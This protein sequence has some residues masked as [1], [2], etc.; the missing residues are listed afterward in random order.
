MLVAMLSTTPGLA[1]L[2]NLSRERGVELHAQSYGLC[3]PRAF[4]TADD[5]Q[6]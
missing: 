5:D 3:R 2:L 4:T 6:Q 1:R